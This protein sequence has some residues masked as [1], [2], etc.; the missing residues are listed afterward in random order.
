VVRGVFGTAVVVGVG[1]CSERGLPRRYVHLRRHFLVGVSSGM[2]RPHRL[3]ANLGRLWADAWL[4]TSP[5][6]TPRGRCDEYSSKI[7][8]QLRSQGMSI[9]ERRDKRLKVM[10][11]S[12][13][14]LQ[15]G[16]RLR[17]LL[18]RLRPVATRNLH[19]H[20][21][22]QHTTACVVCKSLT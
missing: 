4:M 9:L 8:P 1:R 21:V 5:L 6:G 12:L 2:V 15:Q 22:T 11:T 20:V 7:F 14:A 13:I 17:Y 10:R 18:T 19:T 3:V 16:H